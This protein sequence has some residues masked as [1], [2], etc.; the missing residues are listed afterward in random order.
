MKT[1]FQTARKERRGAF[2]RRFRQLGYNDAMP[3]L[4]G[5]EQTGTAQPACK[6]CRNGC[7]TTGCGYAI[8]ERPAA[9]P[10][11]IYKSAETVCKSGTDSIYSCQDSA[12]CGRRYSSKTSQ[13]CSGKSA[14][15][16][17]PTKAE[18]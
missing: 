10:T 5:C 14:L 9:T 15:C 18:P 11:V 3:A 8:P 12:C 2:I 7:K 4:S 6:H 16:D 17:G 13:F 1:A